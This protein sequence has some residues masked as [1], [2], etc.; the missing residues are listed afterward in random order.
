MSDYMAM[1]KRQV[2]YESLKSLYVQQFPSLQE[3]NVSSMEDKDVDVEEEDE[4]L[5]TNPIERK[6]AKIAEL[7]K[8]AAQVAFLQES[9]LKMKGGHGG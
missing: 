3:E 6:D 8:T 7:E 4:L 2:G 1:L 5:P 9:V